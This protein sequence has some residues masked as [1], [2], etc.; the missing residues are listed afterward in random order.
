MMSLFAQTLFLRSRKWVAGLL[1]GTLLIPLVL[2]GQ[3]NVPSE[4]DAA[5]AYSAFLHRPAAEAGPV[6]VPEPSEKAVRFYNLGTRIWAARTLLGLLVPAVFLFSRWSARLG[7]LI[8]RHVTRPQLVIA[9][10]FWAVWI[11]NFVIELPL[12]YYSSF[13]RLHQFGLSNQTFAKWISDA[14]KEVFLSG[15]LGMLCVLL[16]FKLIRRFPK[17]WWL[18]G[19]LCAVPL[20][21]ISVFLKPIVFDPVFNDFSRMK[22]R[23]LEKSIL[24]L[25]SKSGIEGARVFEVNKSVDTKTVNAYVTGFFGT[26]RIVVWD[27][28]LARLSERELLFVMA[29]EMG[30]YVLGHVWKGNLAFLVCLLVALKLVATG[31]RFTLNRFPNRLGFDQ[32][33]AVESLPLLV[34]WMQIASLILIPP[35]FAYSRHLEHE[36]DRFALE[37]T[38]D[39]VAGAVSFARMQQDNLAIPRP[40]VI[41]RV[42]RAT[43]ESVARRIEFCNEYRPWEKGEPLRYRELIPDSTRAPGR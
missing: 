4:P 3:T 27:T 24:T 18:W 11:L 37:T 28:A 9:L 13:V 1:A 39:N 25:A 31:S 43:H 7:S 41:S 20:M 23:A 14:F 26:K 35:G 15:F 5:D 21:V 16:G 22:N 30:H 36:A 19:G 33:S 32:L 17:N 38:R 42:W 40:G 29:H 2:C 34:L 10:F 8:R 6:P 12:N